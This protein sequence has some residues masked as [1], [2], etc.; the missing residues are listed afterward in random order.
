MVA[1][2]TIIGLGIRVW[3]ARNDT[4]ATCRDV[5]PSGHGTWDPFEVKR[6]DRLEV[7]QVSAGWRWHDFIKLGVGMAPCWES[8]LAPLFADSWTCRT[9]VCVCV[10]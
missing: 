1:M 4:A 8:A 5:T 6:G 10:S 2:V 3:E 9:T 7:S